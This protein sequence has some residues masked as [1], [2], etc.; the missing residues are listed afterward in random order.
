VRADDSVDLFPRFDPAWRGSSFD[1][2]HVAVPGGRLSAAVRW[3]GAR[4]A[5]LWEVDGLSDVTITCRS[6]DPQWSA[7]GRG[8][9]ALLG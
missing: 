5:L 9:D 2:R 7:T 6:I 8:A 3:H 1:V 4:A